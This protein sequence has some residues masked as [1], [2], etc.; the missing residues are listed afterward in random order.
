MPEC[1]KFFVAWGVIAGKDR[2]WLRKQFLTLA[3][4]NHTSVSFWM[5]VPLRELKHWIRANNLVVE[6]QAKVR[7]KNGR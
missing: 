7:G 3:Q 6:E 1:K 2:L 5:E 4:N